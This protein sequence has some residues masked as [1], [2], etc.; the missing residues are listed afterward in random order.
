MPNDNAE[1]M[2]EPLPSPEPRTT[3]RPTSAR[4]RQIFLFLLVCGALAALLYL[5]LDVL[6]RVWTHE[7]TDDA[8]IETGIVAVS[9]QVAGRVAAV[10]VD[11]NQWVSAGDPLIEIEPS[12]YDTALARK[13]AGL[14]VN[15]SNR[16]S[17]EAAYQ[18]M[19]AKVTSAE[20]S[21][22]QSESESAASQATADK[23]AADL[24]RAEPLF[25]QKVI[26]PE[27]YDLFR[28]QTT[29]AKARAAADRDQVASDQSK[30]AEARAQLNAV[31]AAL[32]MA[33]AQ[34]AQSAADVRAAELDLSYTRLSAPTNGFVTRKAVHPGEYVQVG[35][36]LLAVVPTNLWVVANFKETQLNHIQ[37]GFTVR[38]PVDAY[39]EHDL[40]GHV[41]S[42]QSGTGAR[43]SLL[44]P[45]NAVGNYVKVV[46]RVPVKIV[47]NKLPEDVATLGPGMS[48]VPSVR[49]SDFTVPKVVLAG[50]AGVLSVLLTAGSWRL[51]TQRNS[52]RRKKVA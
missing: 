18:L 30:V 19:T 3:P 8:F 16:K 47:I 51:A 20:A 52:N 50:A 40:A 41:D 6:L 23:A 44:P 32:D 28:T 33:M 11:D 10:H 27:E 26:S 2:N 34:I 35:Q 42:I 46:Q 48:V 22:R 31:L 49:F 21:V 13:R 45:E 1:L 24:R 29:A 36:R 15:Q 14:Q 4:A 38:I 5:G 25:A 37:P 39:P 43:F 7:T 9:P 12:D 17:V